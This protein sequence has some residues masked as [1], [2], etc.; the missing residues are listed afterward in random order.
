MIRHQIQNLLTSLTPYDQQEKGHINDTLAWI[1]SRAPLF[2]TQKPNIPNKH[3][4]AYFLL[5]DASHR[6][7]L[8]VHHR[9]ADLW[10]PSGGHVEPDE[11][12]HETVQRE[13]LEELNTTADF[14]HEAPQFLTVTQ[15]VGNDIPHTDVS[16][17][18]ILKGNSEISYD[19]D[20]SEFH[21][22]KWYRINEI[23][24]DKADP[25]MARFINK[26]NATIQT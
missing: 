24:Y 4:V 12:P 19:Y 25:H 22:I 21:A 9:K 13:C 17:W 23:P 8:L 14:W 26:L 2:R 7:V 1:K 15:T 3:L 18:Y 6:K 10:L 16:L 11:L 20:Q 5:Y